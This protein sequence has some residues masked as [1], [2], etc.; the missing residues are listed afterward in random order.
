MA[1][2]SSHVPVSTDPAQVGRWSAPFNIPITAVHAAMLPTG[3]VL[4]YSYP[5]LPVP[6][7]EDQDPPN[8]AK[9][10]LWNPSTG[11]QKPV[12][13]PLWR[14]PVDGQLKPVNIWCSGQSFLADGR[15][16]VTGGN[17][18]YKTRTTAR[19]GAQQGLHLQPVQRDLD[20]AAQHAQ[21]PLVSV[22]RC[23]S[24]TAARVIL[25]GYD[26]SGNYATAENLDI[27]LFTPSAD[28]NGR[29]QVSLLGTRNGSGQPPKGGLYPH[30]FGMPSGRTLVA[31]PIPEDTWFLNAPGPGNVLSWRDAPA[32]SRDRLWGTAV[33]LP[34]GTNG[35]TRVMQLGGSAP[36]FVSAPAPQRWAFRRRRRSTSPR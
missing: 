19:Q 35:S 5:K 20:G 36:K 24:R 25:D 17:L 9:A 6:H 26:A 7:P 28:L 29:G 21:G 2:V 11:A 1:H 34:G 30:L 4:W 15:L 23:S 14:D 27:E 33:L 13:P 12:D 32:F 10:W 3:K 16:L 18:A 8:T 31:G 22:Q